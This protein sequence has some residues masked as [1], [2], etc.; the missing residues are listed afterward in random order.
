M[1][2]TIVVIGGTGLLG[3]PVSRRLKEA[4]FR[5]RIMTRDPHK[6][7]KLFD[8]SFEIVA[9]DPMGTSCLEEA[10]HGC[11]GVHI[12]LPTEVEQ[13]VAEAVAKLAARHGVE[14]ISYI[15]GATVAEE[16]RW[17]P[18]T[19][20]KF[21]AEQAIREAGIPYTIFCPTWFMESL[22][23]FVVQG[24][25]SIL[26]KQPYPY[27]WLAAEDYARMVASA[28]RLA[29]AANQRFIV[30]GPEAIGMHEALRRYCAVFHPEIKQVSAMPIWLVKLL[31]T[32]TRN[33]ELK[34]AGELMAYFDKVGEGSNQPTDNRMLGAPTTTLESWLARRK[35]RHSA[36]SI[37][38]VDLPRS[39]A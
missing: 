22:P 15:S 24:R 39:Y 2:K 35:A 17:F 32:L 31:A 30:H 5:V 8:G 13:P 14:R 18:M 10:L 34:G 4:G 25:A 33:Q 28:Y 26:G 11:S 20:R 1:Q 29:E 37:V 7:S 36:A 19:N 12:S 3:Q 27:H 23:L 21:L 38:G 9:G 16:N 6:A